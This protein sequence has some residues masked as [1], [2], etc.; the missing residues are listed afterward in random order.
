[1]SSIE[2]GRSQRTFHNRYFLLTVEIK[3]YNLSPLKLIQELMEILELFLLISEL[4]KQVIRY[5]LHIKE[6]YKL[7]EIDLNFTKAM[8][9]VY[10]CVLFLE[11]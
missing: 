7:I 5:F 9:K 2:D 1:M 8:K 6:N 4:P 11:K 3:E 10:L